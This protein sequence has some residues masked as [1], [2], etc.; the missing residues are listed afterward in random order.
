MVNLGMPR[1]R[2]SV[3][4]DVVDNEYFWINSERV[5][6]DAA[7]W[8]ANLGLPERYFLCSARFITKKN[9][10]CLISAYRTFLDSCATIAPWS[11]V[12]LGDGEQRAELEAAI[13]EAGLCGQVYLPGFRQIDEL[14][15]FYALANSFILPSTTE[16]WG[17]VVN[18]AMASGLPVLVSERCGCASD[19]VENGRN[20]FTIDPYDVD[21]IA[22][23]M[24]QMAS[25]DCDLTAMGKASLEIID[26]WSPE[27][28][29]AG[30]EA[31]VQVALQG[32]KRAASFLD[33]VLLRALSPR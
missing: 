17:L 1:E 16:Q 8:R 25:P 31:A 20:G 23:L 24:A 15:A 6:A 21:G 7:K 5:R 2:V 13:A 18:E 9:L 11:L 3:G 29:A 26:R 19:L 14:P 22:G 28:F 32:E 30:L 12:I 27:T 33:R 4:Y 10:L